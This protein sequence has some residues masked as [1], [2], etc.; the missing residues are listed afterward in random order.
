MTDVDH[1]VLYISFENSMPTTGI[2]VMH[3]ADMAPGISTSLSVVVRQ[4][5]PQ[6]D[7]Y[8]ECEPIGEGASPFS[9]HLAPAVGAC[10]RLKKMTGEAPVPGVVYEAVMSQ[11]PPTFLDELL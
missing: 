5:F 7:V 10:V 6:G 3:E 4:F 11:N 2:V 8:V 1:V 9:L